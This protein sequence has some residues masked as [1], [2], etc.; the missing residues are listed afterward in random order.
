MKRLISF[1]AGLLICSSAFA[2]ITEHY[3]SELSGTYQSYTYAQAVQVAQ[4]SLVNGTT[5]TILTPGTTNWTS[6]GFGAATVGT[7]GTYNNAAITGSGGV[8]YQS[9]TLTLALAGVAAGDRV[10]I[11]ADGTY[12]RTSTGDLVGASGTATSPVV[13][14]GF[15][16]TP[17]DGYQGR[18]NGNGALITTNLP[19]ITYTSGS[20]S[21]NS[22]TF[23]VYDSLNISS[24]SAQS[25]RDFVIVYG[26]S[27][28][29]NSVI[30]DPDTGGVSA[31]LWLSSV[32]TAFNDDI[33]MN[34]VTGT[35]QGIG[36][37]SAGGRVANCR[38]SMSSTNAAA[39]GI[40]CTNT[41]VV[42]G[43]QLF[44]AGGFGIY[45]SQTS[46]QPFIYGNT[47]VGFTDD[48]NVITANTVLQ[49]A[50]DNM[51]TDCTNP[52]NAVSSANAL[53]LGYNRYRQNTAGGTNTVANSGD[54]VTA[55]NY[56]S[57]N[58]GL[59]ATDYRN[60]ASDLRLVTTSPAV[61]SGA[62]L[63][64]AIGALQLQ[65]VASPQT[66]SAFSY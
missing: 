12:A 60:V 63:Y 61:N 32:A 48:M 3:V 10:N 15:L 64:A 62:F 17:G 29:L 6:I 66:S 42:V 65:Y 21:G 33:V 14:R 41:N 36:L 40:V 25:G 7:V 13:L 58:S 38:V 27:L 43:N 35:N 56:A 2:A 16:T 30:T 26:N 4:A 9:T 52:I 59:S 20:F 24:A 39:Y 8:A 57:V 46:G 5:Y 45:V 22:K 47:A 50:F 31:G 49:M 55:T 37:L 34:G 19:S 51:F 28:I 23:V 18:T 1:L 54:W 53:A 44:G 11:R